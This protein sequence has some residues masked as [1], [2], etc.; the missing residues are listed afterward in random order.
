MRTHLY[1]IGVVAVIC[2]LAAAALA[3]ARTSKLRAVALVE[4]FGAKDAPRGGRVVP[5]VILAG[6][7][8]YDASTYYATP[9][10]LALDPGTVYEALEQGEPVG[11]FTVARAQ[12]QRGAWYGLGEWKTRQVVERAEAAARAAE[13]ERTRT[14]EDDGPPVLRKSRP[15]EEEKD[16]KPHVTLRSGA[17]PPAA[18]APVADDPDRP[19]LRRGRGSQVQGGAE[20]PR[21][22][23]TAKRGAATQTY[24]AVSDP[25]GTGETRDYRFVWTADEQ[26]RLTAAVTAL[27]EAEVAKYRASRP[28]APKKAPRPKLTDVRVAG[29]DLDLNNTPEIVLEA[30][31]GETYVT[32]IASTDYNVEA[33]TLLAVVTDRERLGS[34]ARLELL[35]PVDADGNNRGELLFRETGDGRYRY[36]IYRAGRDQVWNVWRG[37]WHDE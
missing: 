24:V 29:Y 14:L 13:R 9:R 19:T 34:V 10:P 15:G 18:P 28:G 7:K 12:Q 31:A 2:L 36:A 30:T 3:Q 16:E 35:G 27:A 6:G 21:E 17:E 20:P 8:Y 5:V 32:V 37:G 4:L 1:R 25:S 33:K 11:F 22:V 23:V 26:K